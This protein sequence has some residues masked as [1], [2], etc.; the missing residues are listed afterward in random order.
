MTGELSRLKKGC[1]PG[2][3]GFVEVGWE[4]SG[5]KR[6]IQ[7]SSRRSRRQCTWGRFMSDGLCRIRA[8]CVERTQL[9]GW[10]PESRDS[11][12]ELMVE[13]LSSGQRSLGQESPGQVGQ[14]RVD[15]D[16]GAQA[17]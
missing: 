9:I 1:G 2:R 8:L 5:R 4:N 3:L 17:G 6:T 12:R 14:I 16:T 13:K 10:R 11:D 7:R 15:Q